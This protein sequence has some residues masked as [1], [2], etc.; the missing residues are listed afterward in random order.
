MCS[1][2]DKIRISLVMVLLVISLTSC[3]SSTTSEI[4]SYD[5]WNDGYCSDCGT[6]LEYESCGNMYHYRCP[7]CK[8]EYVFNS[9]QKY[10]GSK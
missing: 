7:L 1:T 9:V 6:R 8:K 4:A 5:N 2:N 10:G 3:G